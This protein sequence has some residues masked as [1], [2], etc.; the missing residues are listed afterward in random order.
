[1][2]HVVSTAAFV[3]AAVILLA[4]CQGAVPTSAPTPAGQAI[5]TTAPVAPAAT[6]APTEVPPTTAATSPAEQPTAAATEAAPTAVPPTETLAPGQAELILVT[7]DSFAASEDVIREFEK[8]YNARV[9]ILKSGDAGAA[10]NK[11]ILAGASNPL[12]DAFFGVDNTFFSRAIKANIFEAYRPLGAND[13][14]QQFVLDP[15]FRLTPT[16]YGD[17]CLNY[18]I[19]W[20]KGKNL[21]PP[22]SLEDLAKPEYKSL[23]VVENPATS[24]PGLAFLLATIGHFGADKYVDYW[25]SLRANDVAVS[26]GWEDAYYNQFTYSGKGD[27][28]IVVSYATSPA[29]EVFFSNGKLTEPPTGNVLGDGACIR[30]IE[31][32]GL[33]KGAK[34]PDLAKKF[35]DYMLSTRFQEDVP[36]QMFV[37]PVNPNAKLPDFWKFAQIAKNPA[38]VS[39][40]EIDANRDKWINA[41][42][43]TVLR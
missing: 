9:R 21:A 23:V 8:Q 13:I 5:A 40:D 38:T 41:W 39:P 29:A 28:P 24:S 43:Q 15:Q 19:S 34:H 12:G 31:F 36:A 6:A 30:Q 20:F 35:I 25:K 32:V 37:Y 27:R 17:V 22:Q 2:K 1:M 42:T 4:A 26:E 14:P 18:D 16:D 33:L 7:H 10:L 3:L 11:E